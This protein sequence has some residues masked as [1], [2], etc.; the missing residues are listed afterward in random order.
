MKQALLVID[1]QNVYTDET[2]A[3][4]VENQTTVISNIN[5]L[6]AKYQKDNLIVYIAH[7]NKADGS[8]SGRMYDYAG[9]DG[10]VEFVEGT[11]IVDYAPTLLMVDGVHIVKHKYDS[12]VGTNLL[13]T[14]KKNGVEKV[15]IVGFMT[16]FCCESTAR[17]AHDLDLYVDFVRDATGTPG[18][19]EC[20][21]ELLVET[22]CSTINNGFGIVVNTEDLL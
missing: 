15:V 5:K 2:S 18:T 11:R 19:A 12:F 13:E 16:N 17:T 6:I 9:E 21:P 4:Y 14:L 22:T 8:D 10:Q 3:Y 20:S 1:V 7:K